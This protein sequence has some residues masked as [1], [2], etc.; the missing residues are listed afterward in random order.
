MFFDTAT[1]SERSKFVF[2]GCGNVMIR[3][4]NRTDSASKLLDI[5]LIQLTKDDL[6][7]VKDKK[8]IEPQTLSSLTIQQGALPTRFALTH[9]DETRTLSTVCHKLR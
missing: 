7:A 6:R 1:N 2:D 5:Q 8:D 3:F 9:K 4:I